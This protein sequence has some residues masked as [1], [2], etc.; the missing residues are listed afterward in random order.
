MNR[1]KR[2]EKILFNNFN[3]WKI[4]V[5][6]VSILHKGHGHFDGNQE[7]HFIITLKSLKKTYENKLNIHKKVNKLL[8][9]EFSVGLHS[10]SIKIIN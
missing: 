5:K 3:S 6:D 2:I 10:L 9:K 4:D 1:K 8:K 7:S